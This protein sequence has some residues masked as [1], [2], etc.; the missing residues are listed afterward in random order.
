MYL[1]ALLENAVP[2]TWDR[3]TINDLGAYNIYGW[4]ERKDGQRDF[5][6]LQIIID[7]EGVNIN[8]VTSSAK[9]TQEIGSI[10]FGEQVAHN[11][12]IKVQE[13]IDNAI[14]DT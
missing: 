1:L 11:E 6:L 13:L 5:V 4:I 14:K 10:L 12:C 3:Y 7:T 9:Y 2:I 8:Y